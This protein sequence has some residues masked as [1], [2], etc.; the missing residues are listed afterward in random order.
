MQPQQ[1]D[2]YDVVYTLADGKI[3][4]DLRGATLDFAQNRKT[5]IEAN[6]V[7]I[8]RTGSGGFQGGT[9]STQAV[10]E[11]RVERSERRGEADT[12][13]VT[14]EL[15]VTAATSGT[16][17]YAEL[18]NNYTPS[19]VSATVNA[20][21]A[22]S[23]GVEELSGNDIVILL[24]D[25]GEISTT[26]LVS[27]TYSYETSA[28]LLAVSD[29]DHDSDVNGTE[30][31][32]ELDYVYMPETVSVSTN[33]SGNISLIEGGGKYIEV[34]QNGSAIENGKT[35]KV[36]YSYSPQDSTTIPAS[37][38]YPWEVPSWVGT[39]QTPPFNQ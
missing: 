32:F 19:S 23:V 38:E 5:Y 21:G 15:S 27:A 20:S 16:R 12:T 10:T 6:G 3:R 39:P 26:D 34:L 24:K 11:V 25:G 4:Y 17:F 28:K 8:T 29:E 13:I 35:L 36:S 33:A 37:G 1:Q 14:E 22:L 2:L 9:K 31:T 7:T 18:A 30:T